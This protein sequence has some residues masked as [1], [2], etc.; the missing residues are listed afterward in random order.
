LPVLATEKLTDW[1][2]SAATLAAGFETIAGAA[3]PIVTS[4]SR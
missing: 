3:A 2:A 4:M 1:P